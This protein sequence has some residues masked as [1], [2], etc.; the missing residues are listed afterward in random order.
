M[1]LDV[2]N[3][4]ISVGGV[5]GGGGSSSFVWANGDDE[6]IV[7]ANE[8]DAD[9]T[10]IIDISIIDGGVKPR[11]DSLILNADGRFFRVSTE[12]SEQEGTVL[13]NLIAVSGSGGGG[14]AVSTQEV[15]MSY[16][17]STIDSGA[18]YVYGQKT[19]AKFSGYSTIDPKVRFIFTIEQK[20][21]L[22]STLRSDLVNNNDEYLFDLSQLPK[23]NNITLTVRIE[24][25]NMSMAPTDTRLRRIFGDIST[26]ELKINKDPNFNATQIKS[27]E[28]TI[29][30]SPSPNT[31]AQTLHVVIDGSELDLN[32]DTTNR[33][34]LNWT[35]TSGTP[36]SINLPAL[37]H[38][39]HTVE[40]FV[41]SV[42]NG[43]TLS[44]ESISY[45]LAWKDN[46]SAVP[47]IW[48][49]DYDKT[50]IQYNEC[51]IPFMIY[52]PVNEGA[53]VRKSSVYLYHNGTQIPT[54]PIEAQYD[55]MQ[56]IKWDVS[57]LV[58][59]APGAGK[60][61][62][63]AITCGS[64]TRR[65]SIWVTSEGAR[66]LNIVSGDLLLNL[67]STGRS[68]QESS[69]TRGI[70]S[71]TN[72]YNTTY[73]TTFTDFNWYNNGWLND[74]D[75]NGAYLSIANGAKAT[76]NLDT[77][78]L[79]GNDSYTFEIRF[80]VRNIQEYSTLIKTI[81]YYYVNENNSSWTVEQIAA[82][83]YTYKKDEDGNTIMDKASPK[84]VSTTGGV[85]FKY[86]NNQGYGFCIGTQEAYFRT[87]DSIANVRYKEDEI[88]NLSFVIQNH[89]LMSI[90]LNGILSGALNLASTA[91][92]QM[93]N[94]KFEITSEFCDVDI[95][96]LRI[97]RGA[98]GMPEI[99][100]NYIS[101]IHSV[102]LYDQNQLT[103]DNDGTILEYSKLLEYNEKYPDNQSMPYAVWEIIDNG[104]PFNDP[105]DGQHGADDDKLPYF[106][107]NDRYCK[108]TFVN[109]CL[110]RALEKGE[111]TE[112][113]YYTHSPSFEAIGAGINVQGTSSQAY[114]R[115]NFKTKLKSATNLDKNKQ[116]IPNKED[117]KWVYTKGSRAG[118]QIKKWNMDNANCA[119]NK[120]TW[121]IDYMESSGSYNTGFAN[122]VGNMYN[123]HPLS[124]YPAFDNDGTGYR[125][126]VYGFPVLVF[127]KHSTT[128]DKALTEEQEY[129]AYE[130]IG[131]YNFNLD[132]SSNEY[133]GFEL[134]NEHPYT[135]DGRT[136]AEVAECWELR[137]NQGT[138][139]S[140][141]YADPSN[142][143]FN[144]LTNE[145]TQEFNKHFEVRYNCE[146]DQVEYAQGVATAAELGY[147]DT[148]A[149]KMADGSTRDLSTQANKNEYLKEKY[150][151]LKALFDW[152]ASTDTTNV[153]ET[154]T[155]VPLAEPA[156]FNNT[157]YYMVETVRENGQDVAYYV[158]AEGNQLVKVSDV[159]DV[160]ANKFY[161]Y[162]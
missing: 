110:D 126:S 32:A 23:G 39:N 33:N 86:L 17:N 52:N 24:S 36:V 84:N 10:Y 72:R 134:E 138:W 129:Q 93:D 119:T 161:V 132:K 82:N 127:H 47:I 74:E 62:V 49:G 83:H 113:F 111:I 122:L 140:F 43:E 115:R 94:D 54:S 56:W 58:E 78:T 114:P 7:K 14:G 103:N 4:R 90:Y 73:S 142:P 38:G 57:D 105:N 143:D 35:P 18:T 130:Y 147:K 117:W 40:M 124:T 85:I 145:G 42:I 21:N 150:S 139:T 97:Y 107:G 156:T 158:D 20:G 102:T 12:E 159:V 51:I 29:S 162:M 6:T 30:F 100:H 41:S 65:I 71:Y 80:R 109:P 92:F 160:D 131:R 157:V 75:G 64:T 16:D 28:S 89:N 152:L 101:D 3:H 79:N 70:W 77:F 137:D 153:P 154:D 69:N 146:G 55:A 112:D 87:P 128:A 141:K 66:D 125:T 5:A 151:N 37:D 135:N 15:F 8:D 68:N 98:L 96:K 60:E 1:Y 45:D 99:I 144:A 81:P 46:E 88:I 95:Y 9:T 59:A 118:Q 108:I 61:N 34:Y 67:T 63:F 48:L 133:Y 13:A 25:A 155:G 123:Y 76:I 104:A 22:I 26:V 44:S 121:K 50:V 106:K 149:I 53:T 116:I 148:T 120:F 19:Y 2:D 136:I 27:G 31:L 11:P 91:L